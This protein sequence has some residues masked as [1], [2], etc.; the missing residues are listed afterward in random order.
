MLLETFIP[1]ISL[2]EFSILLDVPIAEIKSAAGPVLAEAIKRMRKGTIN[3]AGGYDGEFGT[4][5]IFK[6]GEKET[7]LPQDKLL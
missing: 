1:Q 4:V 2:N 7:L 5:Q 3:V 6:D